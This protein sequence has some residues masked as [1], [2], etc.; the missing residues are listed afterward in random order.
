MANQARLEAVVHG[1]VQGVNFRFYTRRQAAILGLA[2]WVR[3]RWD[4]TVEVVAESE[5][6]RLNELLGWL[7]HGPSSA[8][9]ERVDARWTEPTGEVSSFEVHY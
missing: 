6:S 7:H 4:G 5:R 1:I 3:N 9:V 2:G 8:V